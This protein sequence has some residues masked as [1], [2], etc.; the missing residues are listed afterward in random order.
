MDLRGYLG[1]RESW[2]VFGRWNVVDRRTLRTFLEWAWRG[3]S[4]G[5]ERVEGWL[6][7]GSGVDVRL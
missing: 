2:R 4:V 7:K 5:V 1:E 3:R 6:G